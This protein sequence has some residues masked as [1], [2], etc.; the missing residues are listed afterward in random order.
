MKQ[1]ELSW[2]N[3]AGVKV[4]GRGWEP[5]TKPKAIILLVHGLGEHCSR[6][7]HFAQFFC[8]QGIAVLAADRV[9]HGRSEGKRGHVAKYEYLLDE[10]SKLQNE[11][12]RLHSQVPVFV[13][14]HSMGG[15][16]VLNYLLRKGS[17]GIKGFIA[18]APALR[19]AFE[20]SKFI[21]SLGRLMR[22]IYPGFSQNNQLN[23]DQLSRDKNVVEIY[24]KDP[25]VHDKITSET[26]IGLLE[27]GQYCLDQ[28]AK[29]VSLPC[30]VLLMHGSADGL[31][32]A[33]GTEEF[34]QGVKGDVSL[35]IW[36]GLY[37]EIH[38]EPE[39]QAVFEHTLN[40]INS[41]LKA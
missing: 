14:G 9:G 10:V 8:A 17:T 30:P 41:K 33:S 1:Y 2:K 5:D 29:G 23:V 12:V 20:P 40:W 18:T 35:K 32:A 34:A 27:W 21:L 6:Y 16:I 26:G 28:A 25:L 22:K 24:K 38:N 15:N 19:L 4:Y 13:Y 3:P 31:T 7:E 39:K 36:E 37:H 11:A